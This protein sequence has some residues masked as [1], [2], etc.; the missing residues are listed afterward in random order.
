ALHLKL[1]L[2]VTHAEQLDRLIGPAHEPRAEQGVGSD[3]DTLGDEA[4]VADVHHLRVLLERV[5]EAPL[6]NAANER[7]LAAFEARAD[8]LPGPG[9]LSL[10]APSR[11][12]A[13]AR[14]GPASL[15]DAAT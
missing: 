1:A 3:L 9:R 2:H 6:R 5:R 14:A 7:H 10:A 11:R 4:Q 8:L 13:D 15:A 12:L